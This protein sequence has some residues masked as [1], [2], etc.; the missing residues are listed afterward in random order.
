MLTPTI[1]LH[2]I[3]LQYLHKNTI[4]FDLNNIVLNTRTSNFHKLQIRL[5]LYHGEQ[6]IYTLIKH[7]WNIL[8]SVN[9]VKIWHTYFFMNTILKN[10]KL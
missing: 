6:F 2:K 10:A 8:A 7:F 9:H 4:N 1:Y 5:T 3:Q